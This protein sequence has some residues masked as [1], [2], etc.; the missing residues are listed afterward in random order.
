MPLCTKSWWHTLPSPYATLPRP[1]DTLPSPDA[2]LYQVPMTHS[3]KS[4]CPSAKSWHYFAKS[5]WH[6]LPIIEEVWSAVSSPRGWAQYPASTAAAGPPSGSSSSSRT[7][8]WCA[9]S[10]AWSRMGLALVGTAAPSHHSTGFQS[11]TLPPWSPPPASFHPQ[12]WRPR[13]ECCPCQVGTP[14]HST[15]CDWPALGVSPVTH[16]HTHMDASDHIE[17]DSLIHGHAFSLSTHTH[18][19][20]CTHILIC[21][22]RQSYTSFTKNNKTKVL[23]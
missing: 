18:I 12:V 14:R 7:A 22:H 23:C 5:R 2:T 4:L 9:S 6:S 21:T 13:W 19:H 20:A 1:D 17:F 10:S 11:R 16:T 3:T 15:W 8:S